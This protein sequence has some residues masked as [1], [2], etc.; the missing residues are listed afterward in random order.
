MTI[1]GIDFSC[2]GIFNSEIRKH[3]G[4][5]SCSC[6]LRLKRVARVL[7]GPFVA[8]AVIMPMLLLLWPECDS[9]PSERQQNKEFR[10]LMEREDMFVGLSLSEVQLLFAERGSRESDIEDGD[11]VLVHVVN[12]TVIQLQLMKNEKDE[13]YV[14][15][16]IQYPKGVL[17]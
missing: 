2:K 11:G 7:N 9:E 12:D 1:K 14:H 5:L 6:P 4:F 8:G 16:D 13:Y 3:C 15:H 17:F 10:V